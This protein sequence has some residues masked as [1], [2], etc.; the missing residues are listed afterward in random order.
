MFKCRH[1]SCGYVTLRYILT[2]NDGY[3]IGYHT[4]VDCLLQQYIICG[5]PRS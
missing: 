5:N 4:D 3:H 1:R 2:G